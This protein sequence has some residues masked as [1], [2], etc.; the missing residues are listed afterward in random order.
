MEITQ[1]SNKTGHGNISVT[2]AFLHRNRQNVHTQNKKIHTPTLLK[3]NEI[4]KCM[5][6]LS[7]SAK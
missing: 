4:H 7:F 6:N 3:E 2:T 5:L 1:K